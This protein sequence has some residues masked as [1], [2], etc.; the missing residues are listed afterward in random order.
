MR[1]RA[2]LPIALLL[3]LLACDLGGDRD[4]GRDPSAPRPDV[5]LITIDTL[6]VD[7]LHAYGFGY[8]NSPSLDALAARGVLFE[9]AIAAATLTAPAHASIMTS[10]YVREHSIGTR[11]G[12]TRLEGL[13][14]LAEMFRNGGYD[15]AAYVSNVVLRR[16][17]GL[18]RGFDTYDDE[19]PRSEENRP[20]YFERIAEQTASETM[21]WISERTDERPLFLWLHLQD[22]H[23]PYRPPREWLGRIGPIPLRM[24]RDLRVLRE[25]S[26]RAGIP[27]YQSLD[28][29][30]DPSRYAGFYA[31]EIFY[32]DHWMGRVVAAF[33]ARSERRGSIILL[34][35]DHGE[36]MGEQGWFFQHGQAATPE[37]A[38]VPMI[39]VAPGLR[40][41]RSQALISHVD[42]APTLLALAD[43]PPLPEASGLS[44]LPVLAGEERIAERSIF[45][46]TDGETAL[47][48]PNSFTRIGG[49][50]ASNLQPPASGPN[51]SESRERDSEGRWL[52]T[53][54]DPH[55]QRI[56]FDYLRAAAPL[57][58]AGVM[59][60]RHIEE[61]R[62]LGY[63]PPEDEAGRS[64]S[65]E[66][67]NQEGEGKAAPV[68]PEP[69]RD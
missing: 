53:E 48:R 37:L 60:A 25:N 17:I 26:G 30:R 6:R 18:D 28:E 2:R 64:G 50:I 4:A 11:N 3:L 63:L 1:W 54:T 39:V 61:L 34:T 14:T 59:D 57:V 8:E 29:I 32:A 42:V 65:P 12:D 46:D 36:S 35:A 22:P 5:L 66:G 47:Y 33:E 67:E 27:A 38:R 19:L 20:A 13:P 69:D 52:L 23:G 7:Y 15:T 24:Q 51:Q 43:L 16:R 9:N 44:L 21:R 40:P 10:R 58:A 31:D 56:L 45:C 62:A 41:H 68:Q 49:P 55:S